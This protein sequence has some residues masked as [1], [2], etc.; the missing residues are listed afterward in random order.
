MTAAAA[1][2]CDAYATVLART[3]SHDYK[4]NPLDI[5]DVCT[6]TRACHRWKLTPH[7]N[8]PHRTGAQW[9]TGGRW[10]YQTLLTPS[11]W[12]TVNLPKRAIVNQTAG[13]DHHL[14]SQPLKLPFLRV[15]IEETQCPSSG[16]LSLGLETT[17]QNAACSYTST[18]LFTHTHTHTHK[19]MKNQ[20]Q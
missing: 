2:A 14:R 6:H 12:N 11:A 3:F 5:E 10:E 16:L 20:L 9:L 7:T 18:L 13:A 17:I 8:S 1:A 19:N 15:S 4:A